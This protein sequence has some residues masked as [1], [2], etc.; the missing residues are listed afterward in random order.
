MSSPR[1]APLGGRSLNT[2]ALPAGRSEQGLGLLSKENK[3]I[4]I[5]MIMII[6]IIIS[7]FSNNNVNNANNDNKNNTYIYI[8]IISTGLLDRCRSKRPVYVGSGPPL[9]L[10]GLRAEGLRLAM[11]TKTNIYI[12]IY[13]YIYRERER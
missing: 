9:S 13:I 12:Y 3:K 6:M 8:Y 4:L 5:I 1:K 11:I 7:G 10:V 2:P